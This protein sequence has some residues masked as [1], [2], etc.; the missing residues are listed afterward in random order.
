[1]YDTAVDSAGQGRTVLLLVKGQL[2]NHVA[3][4]M[5]V[6]SHVD[7]LFV[8][9]KRLVYI[10]RAVTGELVIEEIKPNK[11]A[12]ILSA[13]IDYREFV[14]RFHEWRPCEPPKQ[15]VLSIMEDNRWVGIKP[16]LGISPS[17][18]LRPDGTA[19][20]EFGY[21]ELYRIWLGEDFEGLL[22]EEEPTDEDVKQAATTLLEL[23]SEFS[24]ATDAD[25]YGWLSMVFTLLTRHMYEL[26]PV[27]MFGGNGEG[28]GKSLLAAAAI[29]IS[30]GRQVETFDI[31][32]T[33]EETD[34]RI[35]SF[36]FRGDRVLFCDNQP[37]G[38]AIGNATLDRVVTSPRLSGRILSTSKI[39]SF[40]NNFTMIISGNNLRFVGDLGRRMLI[41][42]IE[43]K[44]ANPSRR[45]KGHAF[46]I[47]KLL[48]HI[49]DN[50]SVYLRASLTA[51]SAYL[52]RG[53]YAI[54]PSLLGSFDEWS[55]FV[56]GAIEW[57][58]GVSPIELIAT[59]DE[60]A[61]EEREG[62]LM[63]IEAIRRYQNVDG[64]TLTQMIQFANDGDGIMAEA[65]L[66]AGVDPKQHDAKL[67]IG[68]RFRALSKKPVV[69]D[70]GETVCLKN[71]RRHASSSVNPRLWCV[72][73]LDDDPD[74]E[75]R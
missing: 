31:G 67:R 42:S 61:N 47:P 41:V 62:H 23:V 50:R 60:D 43:N 71:F 69:T 63:L 9:G 1:M 4:S 26:A 32:K 45:K 3:Q 7:N 37:N 70:S 5:E 15:L 27:Y 11:L 35:T 18:L 54:T 66:S 14:V 36:A 16:L 72:V 68:Y 46:K 52:R 21:D 12:S 57:L 24:F 39:I 59:E 73:N 33:A 8:Y 10:D 6:L 75:P 19:R 65:I 74:S 20:T 13:L 17:P 56:G 51:L 22:P 29:M 2:A 58:F 40:T 34:K 25:R 49:Q 30:E 28:S 64:L 48:Q 55:R 53:Q 38:K 44:V